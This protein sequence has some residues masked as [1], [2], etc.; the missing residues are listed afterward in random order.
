MKYVSN[1]KVGDTYSKAW[2]LT[3]KNFWIFLAITLIGVV[4]RTV[5]DIFPS[6]DFFIILFSVAWGFLIHSPISMSTNWVFL[7]ASR[8]EKF[9]LTDMFSVFSRNYWNAVGAGILSFL[10]VIGGLILLIIP[11]IY[12]A[13]KLTFV[14]YL[15]I[16]K[17]MKV[18]EAIKSSWALTKGHEWTIFLMWLLG[19]LI[20]I[21][22]LVVLIVGILFS[23]IWISS[24]FAILYNSVSKKHK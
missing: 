15:I 17:K 16:D 3:L 12:F 6:D 10:I 14:P 5:S 23:F 18:I 4:I 9:K 2:H 22:G 8:K 1:T 20:A 21:A 19:G 13:I 24:A 7:R 11:G